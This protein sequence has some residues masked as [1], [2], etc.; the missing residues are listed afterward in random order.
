MEDSSDVIS[1]VISPM[2]QTENIINIDEEENE[3]Q[4]EVVVSA[5]E[6]AGITN[7]DIED[8]EGDISSS[9]QIAPTNPFEDKS[10]EDIDTYEFIELGDRVLIDSTMY[11]RVI[12][13]VYYRDGD[14]IRIIP[15]GMSSILVDF[16]VRQEDDSEIFDENLG[17]ITS[18]VI[19]KRKFDSF[20]AQ[21][22]LRV[23][24][25]IETISSKGDLYRSFKI[26][27]VDE[28]IDEITIEDE[29]GDTE[30]VEFGFI[31]IPRDQSFAIIRVREVSEKT[32][33]EQQISTKQ[34]EEQT[35]EQ[36]SEIRELDIGETLTTEE[37]TPKKR[38]KVVGYVTLTKATVFKEAEASQK[39][40]P[41]NLQKIDALND[42]L[43]MLDPM[44]QKDPKAV[45]A[46]RIMVET[47]FHM[48]QSLIEY[49][50]DGTV[51]GTKEIS[52]E[53]LSDLIKKTNVP[54][55]RPVLDV[56]KK[57]YV[58]TEDETAKDNVTDTDTVFFE[59]FK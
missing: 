2:D 12:G 37:E 52:A 14:L 39:M 34:T 51:K 7:A 48:K 1:P 33:A 11:G 4:P 15:D 57:L 44:L 43:N 23:G 10:E 28:E 53:W 24:Q 21:Q 22:D 30:K 26:T 55:S 3:D 58:S 19:D 35:A 20:I 6:E 59:D 9:I 27:E 18:Y 38:V 42:F 56:A 50:Q 40:Y 32:S 16:N 49:N 54:I 36:S 25:N 46:V 5:L 13:Q 31:G 47:Y 17:V 29:N 45:R 41:D 8:I